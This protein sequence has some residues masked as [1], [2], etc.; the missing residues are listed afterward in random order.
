MN[1]TT[2]NTC[3]NPDIF[4]ILFNYDQK[5][6]KG[7]QTENE[8]RA[9]SSFTNAGN[10]YESRL[11]VRNSDILPSTTRA[12]MVERFLSLRE[13]TVEKKYSQDL[14]SIIS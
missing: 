7:S 3:R 10:N 2:F 6:Q 8:T 1:M 14:G 13:N 9:N 11:V 4:E 5:L 12:D